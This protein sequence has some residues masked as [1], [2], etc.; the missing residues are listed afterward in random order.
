MNKEELKEAIDMGTLRELCIQYDIESEEYPE[1]PY[2][3]LAVYNFFS[4]VVLGPSKEVDYSVW[5]RICNNT[6]KENYK[7]SSVYGLSGVIKD[8]N[9]EEH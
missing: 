9:R 1:S 5:K 3:G 2:E 6:E 4:R 7:I 8:E